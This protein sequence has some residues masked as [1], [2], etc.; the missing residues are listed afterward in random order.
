M[1]GAH[2][3]IRKK[4]AEYCTLYR[5]VDL[6][7]N[8]RMEKRPLIRYRICT[9][10]T[11]LPKNETVLWISYCISPIL[12]SVL[13]KEEPRSMLQ[14]LGDVD[15]ARKFTAIDLWPFLAESAIH[16]WGGYRD[17]AQRMAGYG[18]RQVDRS[19]WRQVG[20]AP[21]YLMMTLPK[22]MISLSRRLSRPSSCSWFISPAS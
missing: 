11:L 19:N 9:R 8:G 2:P 21:V 13:P 20:Q 4:T 3:V 18:L 17:G 7:Q 16:E 22:G 6:P 10:T 15:I 14:S 12:Q 5:P 1:N